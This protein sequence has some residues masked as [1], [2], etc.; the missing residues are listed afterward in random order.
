M[1]LNLFGGFEYLIDLGLIDSLD[2]DEFLL[3]G[4]DD[5]GDGAKAIRFEFG[6]IS[7][8]D[9]V[10]LQFLDLDEVG[11]LDFL[12]VGFD[13]LLDLLLLVLRFLFLLHGRGSQNIITYS[14]KMDC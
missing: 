8:I 11:L 5:A 7:C 6:D 13:F 3:G 9:A 4:H 14:S 2:I 1:I 12:I 10:L